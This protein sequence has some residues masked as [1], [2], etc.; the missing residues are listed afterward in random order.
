MSQTQQI[1]NYMQEHGYITSMDAFTKLK[2]TRLAA[3]ISELRQAGYGI[4]TYR[5]NK[6]F[7]DGEVRSYAAYTLETD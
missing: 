6:K 1:L 4:K 2:C 3:R 5:I 7:A